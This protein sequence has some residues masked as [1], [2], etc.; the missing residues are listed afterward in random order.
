[1]VLG[2]ADL[3]GEGDGVIRSG[4]TGEPLRPEGVEVVDRVFREQENFG[5]FVRSR[6]GGAQAGDAAADYEDVG[7]LLREPGGLERDQVT[8]LR[9]G[10]KHWER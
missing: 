4:Q 2:I 3:P 5:A 8:T 7:E 10:L 6:D 1:M 9:E